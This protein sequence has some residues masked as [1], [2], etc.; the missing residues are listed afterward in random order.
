MTKQI[1][2][3]EIY[4]HFFCKNRVCG[5]LHI[6]V[7]SA[8]LDL[9]GI[10]FFYNVKNAHVFVCPEYVHAIE[11]DGTPVTYPKASF[12]DQKDFIFEAIKFV[13]SKM[14]SFNYKNLPTEKAYYERIRSYIQSRNSRKNQ[15]G[16]PENDRKPKIADNE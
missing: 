14:K 5:T 7:P 2:F 10:K 9:R 13:K 16:H 1:E 11:D 4:P 15:G 3:E 6:F 12:F 8:N